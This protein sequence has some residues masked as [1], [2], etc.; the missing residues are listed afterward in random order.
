MSSGHSRYVYIIG[1]RECSTGHGGAGVFGH[2]V[3]KGKLEL[4][5]S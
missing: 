5:E 2:S 4:V 1:I 3:H